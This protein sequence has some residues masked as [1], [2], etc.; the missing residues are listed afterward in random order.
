MC[1][2]TGID[3]AGPTNVTSGLSNGYL[4]LN[5]NC[6]MNCSPSYKV[7][8]GPDILT[9]QTPRSAPETVSSSSSRPGGGEVT[10]LLNSFWS[11]FRAAPEIFCEDDDEVDEDIENDE[12]D[13][14]M[15]R[16]WQLKALCQQYSHSL[17][18]YFTRRK[19]KFYIKS[20]H[21]PPPLLMIQVFI[22][23]SNELCCALLFEIKI[24][25]LT[26]ERWHL[27]M[28]IFYS[29]FFFLSDFELNITTNQK[30]HIN[31]NVFDPS[32]LITTKMSFLSLVHGTDC[33]SY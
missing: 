26:V 30:Y 10:K 24:G 5:L 22:T 20:N 13:D 11:L 17:K 33:K 12:V 31:L 9:L 1:W 23:W 19:H 28:F 18:K 27:S 16:L 14:D 29:S 7:L 3:S 21:E 15:S 4:T 2:C 32:P 8:L 6:T 25:S